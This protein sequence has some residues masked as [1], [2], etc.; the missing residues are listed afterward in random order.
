[1]LLPACNQSKV[2][3]LIA[4]ERLKGLWAFSAIHPP[5]AASV[6]SHQQSEPWL[7]VPRISSASAGWGWLNVC[8]CCQLIFL[9]VWRWLEGKDGLMLQEADFIGLESWW[10]CCM[11]Q[12]TKCVCSTVAAAF[13]GMFQSCFCHFSCFVDYLIYQ[14]VHR[15]VSVMN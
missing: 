2:C 10:I 4:A 11:H 9:N 8:S 3:S 7:C 12:V 6:L 15:V 5:T 13:L 1:M 14:V